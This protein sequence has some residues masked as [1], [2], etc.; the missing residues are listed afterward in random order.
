[1]INNALEQN[2]QVLKIA[3]MQIVC[4]DQDPRSND[5]IEE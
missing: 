2:K 5:L 1:M 3:L 4:A